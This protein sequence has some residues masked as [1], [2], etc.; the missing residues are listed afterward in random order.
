MASKRAG[1]VA[2]ALAGD[3]DEE[4]HILQVIERRKNDLLLE[5]DEDVYQRRVTIAR[6]IV[7]ELGAVGES[8]GVKTKPV[9]EFGPDPETV[10]LNQAQENNVDLIVIGTGVRPGSSDLYLGPRVEYILNNAPC[11]VIVVNSG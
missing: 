1:E 5:A 3:T 7:D 2:F 11:P 10:I 6:Q 8:L 9:V 4:V